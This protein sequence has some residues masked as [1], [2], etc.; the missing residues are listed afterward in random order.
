MSTRSNTRGGAGRG[1]RSGPRGTPP[2]K[3]PVNRP[4]AAKRPAAR[5]SAGARGPSGPTR[6]TAPAKK[7]RNRILQWVVAFLEAAAIVFVLFF[8]L[9]PVRTEGIGMGP[10]VNPGDRMLVSRAAAALG[11]RGAGDLVLVTFENEDGESVG[12]AVMRIIGEPFDIVT[13]SEGIISVNGQ[14]LREEYLPPGTETHPSSPSIVLGRNEYFVLGDN[15]PIS[16]DSRVFGPISRG[17]ISAR[18]VM[19]IFPFN[20]IRLF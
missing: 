3:R 19:R 5:P 4:G 11:L 7:P 8:V 15:R 12:P 13:I 18:V 1:Q 20:S 17:D 16:G 14:V 6:K 2:N 10:T 9:W